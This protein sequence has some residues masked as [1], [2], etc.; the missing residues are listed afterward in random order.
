VYA[1]L[2]DPEAI[3]LL[4]MYKNAFVDRVL[5]GLIGELTVGLHQAP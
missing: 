2:L 1:I 5:S 3:F 4:K